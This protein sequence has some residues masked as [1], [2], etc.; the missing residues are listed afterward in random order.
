M[1]PWRLLICVLLV[2]GVSGCAAAPRQRPIKGADVDTGPGSIEAVRRQLRGTWALTSYEVYQPS[3]KQEI[4]A[5]AQ[6]T[7]DEFGNLKIDGQ[8]AAD[9]SRPALL[10]YSGR[11]T[12]DPRASELHLM[13][14]EGTAGSVPD[15]VARSLS[16]E[17]TRHYELTQST[18]TL[19][20]V[21]REGK[22]TAK[23]MWKRVS[24]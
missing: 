18:L 13:D 10:N 17:N 11:V 6:L 20:V 9:Q 12:I 21:D 19:T 7:Y 16:P 1:Q 5:Q 2:A 8:V 4:G 15:S 23:S 14:I 22:T 3:G 24:Q